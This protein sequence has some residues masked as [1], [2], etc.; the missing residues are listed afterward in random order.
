V[1]KSRKVSKRL[2]KKTKDV[3]ITYDVNAG[4]AEKQKTGSWKGVQEKILKIPLRRKTL[5]T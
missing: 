5:A 1:A 2:L 3:K 4:R